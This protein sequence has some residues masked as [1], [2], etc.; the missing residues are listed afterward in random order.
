MEWW[1]GGLAE[2]SWKS[3]PVCRKGFWSW[4]VVQVTGWGNGRIQE[5]TQVQTNISEGRIAVSYHDAHHHH[6]QVLPSAQVEQG[7][8]S[9]VGPSGRHSGV[10]NQALPAIQL[11]KRQSVGRPL[12]VTVADGVR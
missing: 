5:T 9:I 6:F 2:L 7:E 4:A 10:V 8:L 3:P 1:K 11:S 12:K